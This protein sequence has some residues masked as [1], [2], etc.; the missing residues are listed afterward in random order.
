MPLNDLPFWRLWR[1]SP[2][3]E[4][5]GAIHLNG[6]PFHG[7]QCLMARQLDVSARKCLHLSI[8][9]NSFRESEW[10]RQ[11]LLAVHYDEHNA[12][13]TSVPFYYLRPTLVTFS[14]PLS[15]TVSR[16]SSR[17]LRNNPLFFSILI[18]GL[19]Q[20]I[21]TVVGT[22]FLFLYTLLLMVLP[23]AS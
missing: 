12:T 8:E 21:T 17:P 16:P 13:G 22:A 7:V 11:W 5:L 1:C 20:P 19:L 14:L 3:R 10:M 9:G 23:F 6:V 2:E 18:L 15:F 4:G